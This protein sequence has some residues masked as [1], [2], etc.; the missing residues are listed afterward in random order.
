MTELEYTTLMEPRFGALELVDVGT[1][2]DAVTE[3][4]YN[5]TLC[6]VNDSL[7]R[8]GVLRGEYHWHAHEHEDEFFYVVDGRMLIELE[9]RDAVELLPRQGFVVPR[10]LRHRPVVPERSIVL[11][12]ERASVVPTGD[13]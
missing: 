13:A 2:A 6:A 3:Q 1:V 4:W 5:E 7:V 9:G 11:M 12:I 10:G 8:L